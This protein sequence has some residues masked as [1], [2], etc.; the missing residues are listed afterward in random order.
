[1]E[2]KLGVPMVF[3][4]LFEFSYTR[5]RTDFR[6]LVPFYYATPVTT[7]DAITDH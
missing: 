3:L 5:K 7:T 2:G 1:M 4:S 6:R